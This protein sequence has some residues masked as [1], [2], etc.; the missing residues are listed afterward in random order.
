M[1]GP[2]WCPQEKDSPQMWKPKWV[3]AV[4]SNANGK[5]GNH[6]R[7]SLCCQ[8]MRGL[9]SC[10]QGNPRTIT[11]LELQVT[12]SEVCSFCRAPTW[13]SSGGVRL[14]TNP[15]PM[16]PPSL[17]WRFTGH[18]KS[19]IGSSSIWT[20]LRAMKLPSAR[21]DHVS[22]CLLAGPTD[23]WAHHSKNS[24][25]W[26]LLSLSE[27]GMRVLDFHGHGRLCKN[28]NLLQGRQITEEIV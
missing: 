19:S 12:Y 4:A 15:S 3:G 14:V 11:W 23:D 21:V 26:C 2:V 6:H 28:T 17:A 16:G 7:I 22:W 20:N 25:F 18:W 5:M 8:E 1:Q 10:N 24:L 27:Q 13:I 9:W